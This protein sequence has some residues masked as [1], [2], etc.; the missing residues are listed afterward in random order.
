[1]LEIDVGTSRQ[2]IAETAPPLPLCRI[3]WCH[4]PL[5][6]SDAVTA[7]RAAKASKGGAA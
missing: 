4:V 7:K 5:D 3:A 1:M 2:K 6:E